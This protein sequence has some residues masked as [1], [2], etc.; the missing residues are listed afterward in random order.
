V[1]GE[2]VQQAG[3]A[4]TMDPITEVPLTTVSKT[5]MQSV[6]AAGSATRRDLHATAAGGATMRLLVRWS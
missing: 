1:Q 2:H 4:A 3:A 5:G 6:P